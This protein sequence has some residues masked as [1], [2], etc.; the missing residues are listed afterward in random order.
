MMYA[1]YQA[2][3]DL[4]WPLRTLA[5]NALPMLKDKTFRWG[6]LGPNRKLAAACEVLKLGEVTHKRPPFGI[7]SVMLRASRFPSPR[8]PPTSRPSAP[9][10]TSRRNSAR[11]GR[12]PRC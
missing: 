7:A 9:C 10:C 5:S 6:E 3:A 4:M 12:N 11:Q 2:H 1:A 8:R